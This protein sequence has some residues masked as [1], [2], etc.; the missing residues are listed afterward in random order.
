M[1]KIINLPINF[2][3]WVVDNEDKLKPPVNNFLVQRGDF[4][5]MAVGGPNQ[6]SDYHVNPTEE[7]F[8]QYRGDMILKVVD[9]N[10]FKDIEIKE[11]EMFLLPADIPHNPCRPYEGSVGIVVER[12]RPV[13][14]ND[15]L[16]WFCEKCNQLVLERTFYC[17]DLGTQ[18]KPLIQEYQSNENLRKCKECGHVSKPF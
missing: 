15:H 11:G 13:G 5:I 18:L 4:I 1:R 8:Y 6:R 16:R 10:E 7:W 3:K 9:D 12:V 17:V 2:D 14:M